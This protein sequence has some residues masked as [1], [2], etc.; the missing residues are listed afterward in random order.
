MNLKPRFSQSTVLAGGGGKLVI[1][2]SADTGSQPTDGSLK[3]CVRLVMLGERVL[4]CG[5]LQ[6]AS[7]LR[8]EVSCLDI[9]QAKLK[10]QIL[11]ISG[12]GF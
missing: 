10:R 1:V 2:I 9:P 5:V 4:L 11:G 3:L 8:S 12:S 6:S 7:Q